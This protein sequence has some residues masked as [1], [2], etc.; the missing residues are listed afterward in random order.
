MVF[1]DLEM[2]HPRSGAAPTRFDDQPRRFVLVVL[3]NAVAERDEEFNDWYD[4]THLP[5][6]LK[7]EGYVGATRFR[8]ADAQL[9]DD[10]DAAVDSSTDHQYLALYE[11]EAESAEIALKHLGDGIAQ[12]VEMSDA[13]GPSPRVLLF[14]QLGPRQSK[15]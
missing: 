5:D 15:T 10:T 14:E 1:R 3:T 6:V 11:I 4:R 12:G 13:L 9:G 2:T 8:V 7:I